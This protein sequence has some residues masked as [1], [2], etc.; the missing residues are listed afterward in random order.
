MQKHSV[1]ITYS[2]FLACSF[3]FV[4]LLLA[5]FSKSALSRESLRLFSGDPLTLYVLLA[6]LHSEK[7]IL[8]ELVRVL[9]QALKE[10]LYLVPCNEASL[11]LVDLEPHVVKALGGHAS[12]LLKET[13]VLGRDG[14]YVLMHTVLVDLH[15][16]R[17]AS[18]EAFF[19]E[20]LQ[21]LL[22]L[23]LGLFLLLLSLINEVEHLDA[24]FVASNYLSVCGLNK[25]LD[26]VLNR[27]FDLEVAV[28]CHRLFVDLPEAEDARAGRCGN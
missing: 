24:F 4:D 9:S 18:V 17:R 12:M 20:V 2:C 25:I 22:L 16:L 5:F 10:R 23:R 11:V 13:W 19:H 1:L 14:V 15:R 27:G 6:K 21:I 26:A 28:N 8:G 7:K 3:L